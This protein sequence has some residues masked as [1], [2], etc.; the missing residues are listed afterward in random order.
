MKEE[1]AQIAEDEAVAQRLSVITDDVQPNKAR[2]K[3][4]QKAEIPITPR[5]Q[6]KNAKSKNP[7]SKSSRENDLKGTS[8]NISE[9]DVLRGVIEST[10][11]SIKKCGPAW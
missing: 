6:K 1:E 3:P 8:R 2:T 4:E 9:A 7:E 10:W 5:Q 11:A